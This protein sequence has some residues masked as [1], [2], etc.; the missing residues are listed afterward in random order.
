MERFTIGRCRSGK[1]LTSHPDLNELDSFD[2]IFDAMAMLSAIA[3]RLYRLR[4]NRNLI[5]HLETTIERLEKLLQDNGQ[6]ELQKECIGATTS[7]D[8]MHHAMRLL[9]PEFKE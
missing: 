3:A 5:D 4:R 6:M 1:I 9:L 2:E 7:V 8:V